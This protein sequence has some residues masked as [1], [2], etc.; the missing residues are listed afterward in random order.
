MRNKKVD[1]S[2]YNRVGLRPIKI[3]NKIVKRVIYETKN[4]YRI[5]FVYHNKSKYG[6]VFVKPLNKSSYYILGTKIKNER[7]LY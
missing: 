1:L 4:I 6:I 5:R 7:T 3:K 2:L